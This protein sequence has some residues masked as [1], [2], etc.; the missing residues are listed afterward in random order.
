MLSDLF[1]NIG[2]GVAN[3]MPAATVRY[4]AEDMPKPKRTVRG[5]ELSDEDVA[6]LRKIVYSEVSNRPKDKKDLEARILF[7]TA[8]NRIAENRKKGK[9]LTLAEVLKQP[10]QYQG[11]NT[12][13]YQEYNR[14]KDF[15]SKTRQQQ[16][17]E[18]VNGMLADVDAGKFEDNTN[19]AFYYQHKGDKIYYDDEKP[20]FV[21]R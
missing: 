6:E 14:P 8:L 16:V 1:V 3:L 2:R 11:Y 7:N 17:D 4:N 20:L 13:L 21:N 9:E 10:N 19:G 12:P 15:L 5:V 18:V